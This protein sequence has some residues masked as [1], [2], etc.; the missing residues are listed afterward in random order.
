MFLSMRAGGCDAPQCTVNAGKQSSSRVWIIWTHQ[1]TRGSRHGIEITPKLLNYTDSDGRTHCPNWFLHCAW[2]ETDMLDACFYLRFWLQ[3]NFIMS[4]WWLLYIFGYFDQM[5]NRKNLHFYLHYLTMAQRLVRH[6][7]RRY[8]VRFPTFLFSELFL[9]SV[10][11][12]CYHHTLLYKDYRTCLGVLG[13][14]Y[15]FI[16]ILVVIVQDVT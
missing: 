4:I 8:R 1:R 10:F 15:K 12:I 14:V 13:I 2:F 11:F 6:F 9:Y 16:V 3:F 5:W 7:M